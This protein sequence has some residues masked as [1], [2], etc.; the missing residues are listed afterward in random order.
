MKH[1]FLDG[2]SIGVSSVPVAKMMDG[3]IS[4]G[5]D[6]RMG[7]EIA[8]GCDIVS[9]SRSCRKVSWRNGR[10]GCALRIDGYWGGDS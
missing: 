9:D 4:V 3:G 5:R 8:E 7:L 6:P 2:I 1:Q 10:L